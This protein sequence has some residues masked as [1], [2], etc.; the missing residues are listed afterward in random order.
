M[1]PHKH[2][3]DLIDYYNA[4]SS[5]YDLTYS[6]DALQEQFSSLAHRIAEAFEGHVVLEVA[7]GTGYWTQVLSQSAKSVLATDAAGKALDVARS[8]DY[9]NGNVAF[10]N[11]DA[12]ELAGVQREFSA[13]FHF[14]WFSHIHTSHV[15]PFLDTF[16]SKL[17][18]GARVL[19]GDDS[20]QTG[21]MLDED[22][23]YFSIRKVK[24]GRGFPILKNLPREEDLLSLL[25]HKA[26][27]IHFSSFEN[28]WLVEY[29][30]N[31]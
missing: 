14:R 8:R 11:E 13:G 26:H 2:R 15:V 18:P 28:F 3:K 5:Y 23:N 12:L 9:P 22:G 30:L 31:E 16:H 29:L 6:I 10:Q 21:G 1:D 20:A 7:C 17:L 24:D 4:R 27:D 25:R 19:F